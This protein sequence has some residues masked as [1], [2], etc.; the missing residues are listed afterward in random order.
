MAATV[1][2]MVDD[3]DDRLERHARTRVFA[4]ALRRRGLHH[5]FQFT[6][7]F[8]ALPERSSRCRVTPSHRGADESVS[9]AT[10]GGVAAQTSQHLLGRCS[11]D[12]GQLS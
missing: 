12:V 6:P 9:S 2:Y 8:A 5:C 7:T 3:V 1:R 4:G 11:F 10:C